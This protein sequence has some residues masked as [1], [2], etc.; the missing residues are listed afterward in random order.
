VRAGREWLAAVQAPRGT[1]KGLEMITLETTS[2]RISAWLRNE[3]RY[4]KGLSALIM[5]CAISP[6]AL[7]FRRRRS[8]P[9]PAQTGQLQAPP[10]RRA[11]ATRHLCQR[12]Y[13]GPRPSLDGSWVS[14]AS[15]FESGTISRSRRNEQPE[16]KRSKSKPLSDDAF[17]TSVL[18]RD[19]RGTQ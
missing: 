3:G 4:A 11:S 13:A 18:G 14:L 5:S 10:R 7:R 19:R 6:S 15:R 17:S 1:R 8:A 12:T 9:G 16:S 2:E